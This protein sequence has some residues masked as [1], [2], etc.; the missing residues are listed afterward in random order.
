MWAKNAHG[1]QKKTNPFWEEKQSQKKSQQFMVKIP[2]AD[3]SVNSRSRRLVEKQHHSSTICWFLLT[4]KSQNGA[5]P[6]VSR[7]WISKAKLFLQENMT[8]EDQLAQFSM[9]K[10]ALPICCCWVSVGSINYFPKLIWLHFIDPLFHRIFFKIW[11]LEIM[12]SLEYISSWWF[13]IEVIKHFAT[14]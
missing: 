5:Q 3:K 1:M 6:T 4:H 12:K 2:R 10:T 11:V 14:L 9:A 13:M 7:I 8:M